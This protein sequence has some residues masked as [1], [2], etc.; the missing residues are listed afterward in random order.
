MAATSRFL[1]LRR[2]NVIIAGGNFGLLAKRGLCRKAAG[3]LVIRA[4]STNRLWL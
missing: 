3:K 2:N 4:E 1:L